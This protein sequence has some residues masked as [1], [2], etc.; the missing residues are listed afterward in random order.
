MGKIFLLL[1]AGLGAGM[2]FPQSRAVIMETI[3]PALNPAYA[4]MTRGEMDQMISDLELA[5]RTS[6][7]IPAGRGE[8]EPWLERRYPQ[9][10]S[11]VDGWD[12]MY[13]LEASRNQFTVISAG[14]DREFGTADDIRMTAE[15]SGGR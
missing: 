13:R 2:Y 1:L 9:E 14:P 5:D 12:T 3:Q 4:W 7:G 10:A 11:R 8:F 15:R 6:G